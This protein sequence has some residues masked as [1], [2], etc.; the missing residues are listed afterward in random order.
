LSLPVRTIGRMT[1]TRQANTDPGSLVVSSR[2]VHAMRRAWSAATSA[3]ENWSPDN[4]S[5]GQ[6]AVTALIVSDFYGGELV[7]GIVCGESHYWNRLPSGAEVDL[8]RDQFQNF[9]LESEPDVR[10]RDFVLSF[11]D[12]THR[13]HLL[14]RALDG[15]LRDGQAKAAQT[16]PALKAASD[17]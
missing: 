6:C 8:T 13:Y 16:E 15:A 11:P 9:A 1:P 10:G 3:N 17:R 5:V 14:W 4:P 7:R 12:T 2:L